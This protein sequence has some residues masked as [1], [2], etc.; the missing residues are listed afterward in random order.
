MVCIKYIR[1]RSFWQINICRNASWGWRSILKIRDQIKPM[2]YYAVGDGKD[3]LFWLD[4]WLMPGF[5]LFDQFGDYAVSALGLG[6]FI[7][8]S[9]L[10]SNG[11]WMLPTTD[12]PVLSHIWQIVRSFILPKVP[13]S[14]QIVW[15]I[16]P[17]GLFSMA[18][19]FYAQS[20]DFPTPNWLNLVWFQGC[21]NKHS[22]F[23]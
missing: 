7:S 22:I 2:I 9:S 17:T 15:S 11:R 4:P 3:T 23:A 12:S 14:N 18:S 1:G 20:A 19:F 5:T 10:I 8:V 6:R 21:L 13:S 16:N